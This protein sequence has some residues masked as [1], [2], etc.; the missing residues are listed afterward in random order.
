MDSFLAVRT[1]R[2]K[3]EFSTLDNLIKQDVDTQLRDHETAQQAVKD[4]YSQWGTEDARTAALEAAH[5]ENADQRLKAV[6]G[7]VRSQEKLAKG[8]ELSAY[9]QQQAMDRKLKL[10]EMEQGQT[11]TQQH[12]VMTPDRV[13]GGSPGRVDVGETAAWAMRNNADLDVEKI[14]KMQDSLVKAGIPKDRAALIAYQSAGGGALSTAPKDGQNVISPENFVPGSG[15][16]RTRE[17]ARDAREIVALKNQ[18]VSNVEALRRLREQGV[19]SRIPVVGSK[20]AAL[21]NQHQRAMNT[22]LVALG[23]MGA[24][25]QG[26]VDNQ[27]GDLTAPDINDFFSRDSTQYAVLDNARGIVESNVKAKLDAMGLLQGHEALKRGGKNVA[28]TA[29]GVA[30]PATTPGTARFTQARGDKAK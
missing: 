16:A 12:D 11:T 15:Y 26:D 13:V 28:A 2:P 1:G 5:Y 3:S 29:T 24:L 17:E 7:G 25:S 23:K 9:L 27:I 30:K 19:T 4:L 21:V 20:T 14:A 22:A 10:L 18:F 8:R 6:M